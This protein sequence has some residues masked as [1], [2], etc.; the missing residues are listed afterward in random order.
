VMGIVGLLKTDAPVP[1]RFQ[2]ADRSVI[3]LGGLGEC[4]NT[5][6]GGTQYAKVILDQLWG[7]PPKLDMLKERTL[8]TAVREIVQAGF[9]ESA[10]DLS[11]G[12]LAVALAESAFG[13]V[14]VKVLFESGMPAEFIL[15]HEGPSRVVV[16]TA[17]PEKV[18]EV[19]ARH[20]VP[21]LVIGETIA[22]RIIVKGL[23]DCS[24]DSLKQPWEAALTEALA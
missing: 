22:D 16:S 5:H 4:D 14:G 2:N 23:L 15:F 21:A 11:D 24:I 8:Q 1:M 6:F 9:V 19:A 7:L 18:L 3:L 17:N 20:E 12:G 10:H 13:G